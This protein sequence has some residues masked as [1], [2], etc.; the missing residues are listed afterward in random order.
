MIFT[1]LL[2]FHFVCVVPYVHGITLGH[3][4]LT[5][6]TSDSMMEVSGG[7]DNVSTDQFMFGVS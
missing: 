2:K 4:D 3:H 7:H 1:S 6:E 5:E